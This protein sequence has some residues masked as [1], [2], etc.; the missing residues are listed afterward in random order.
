[1]KKLIGLSAHGL[2]AAPAIIKAP[3]FKGR[4]KT[5]DVAFPFRMGTGF[6]GDVNRTHPFSVVGG[7]PNVT[8]PPTFYGQPV[9][10]ETDG[11]WR[12]FGAGDGA[13]VNADGITVRPYP[14]QQ[15][16]TTDNGRINI[17]A[18][19]LQTGQVIDILISGFIMVGV[20]GT[21][22]PNGE[23]YIYIAA[24]ALPLV[25]GAFQAGAGAN[26]IGLTWP[27]TRY[28]SANG[29]DGVCELAFNV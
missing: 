12:A 18:A 28:Y 11:T 20:N 6:P 1:M 14:F 3:L 17:G 19:A 4:R 7:L 26:I 25:Q 5:Q 27:K 8:A 16:S 2:L 23:A 29:S 21:V 15:S 10:R 24:T 13:V 9:L 22:T